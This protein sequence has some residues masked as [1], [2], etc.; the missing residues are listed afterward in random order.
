MVSCFFIINNAL[1]N[2]WKICKLGSF[3]SQK[4]LQNDDL[5][6]S[7]EDIEERSH[8]TNLNTIDQAI[9]ETKKLKESFKVRDIDEFPD[10]LSSDVL[11]QNQEVEEIDIL[12]MAVDEFDKLY[13]Y[14][15]NDGLEI[16]D[17]FEIQL[18]SDNVPR[19]ACANHKLNLAVRSAT[20]K[21]PIVGKNLKLLNT[22][23]VKCRN[24]ISINNAFKGS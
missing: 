4:S 5:S 14:V 11:H 7:D 8:V 16:V 13:N 15:L 3:I 17:E 23:A 9:S 10:T 20:I 19:I 24:S 21:H 6:D 22:Y 12:N 18:G 2:F 1:I